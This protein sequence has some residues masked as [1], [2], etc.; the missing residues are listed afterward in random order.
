METKQ[1]LTVFGFAA[2]TGMAGCASDAGNVAAG[3][4]AAGAAYEYSNK[5]QID[6]LDKERDEG[7]ISA[8]EHSRRTEDVK[9]RSLIE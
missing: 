4:A 2:L 8:E 3:A 1:I 9:D 6:R 7:R 5:R